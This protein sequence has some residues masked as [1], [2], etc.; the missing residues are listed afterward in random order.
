MAKHI[1]DRLTPDLFVENRPGRPRT[2]TLTRKEQMKTAQHRRR[3]KLS[4]EG[5]KRVTFWLS[6]DAINKLNQFQSHH[7]FKS[8]TDAIEKVLLELLR[9]PQCEPS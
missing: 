7:A 4:Q 2:S 9:D 6:P 3:Q 1:N 5:K 8:Q